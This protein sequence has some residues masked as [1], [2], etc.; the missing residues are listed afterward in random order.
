M[1]VIEFS[2]R[3]L[4]L[5]NGQL[6]IEATFN[7]VSNTKVG[8]TY[9]SS[10]ITPDVLMNVFKKNYDLLLR[11]FNPEGWLNIT[12]VDETLRI[13]RDDKGNIFVLERTE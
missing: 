4:N 5:L 9:N 6:K 11:I 12:Y 8:I 3:G 13:G 7:V 10:S 2:A 1:N